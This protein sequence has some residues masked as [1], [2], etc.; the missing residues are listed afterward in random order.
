VA[1]SNFQAPLNHLLDSACH[2]RVW[3]DGASTFCE[4]DLILGGVNYLT[5][6]KAEGWSRNEAIA[7]IELAGDRVWIDG[8]EQPLMRTAYKDGQHPTQGHVVYQH[9]AFI[10]QLAVGDHVSYWE[11]TFDGLPDG[12]ATVQLHILPRT[13]AACA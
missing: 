10:T 3:F 4:D 13:D 5:N 6:Y 1:Q 12:S 7:D 2:Y 8:I 9:R 11:G